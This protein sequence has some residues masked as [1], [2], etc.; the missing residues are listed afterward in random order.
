MRS[1]AKLALE[2]ESQEVGSVQ[3]ED[4]DHGQAADQPV[5]IQ[6]REQVAGEHHVL[7]DRHT[8]GQVGKGRAEEQGRQEGAD[9]D[10]PVEGVPPARARILGAVLKGDA[11]HDQAHQQQEERQVEAAEHRG[12]PVRKSRECRAACSQKPDLVAI[13]GWPNGV[14][15]GAAFL[16]LLS[17]EGEQHADAKI[18]ALQEVEADP[19]DGDQDEPD[20]LKCFVRHADLP[21]SPASR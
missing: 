16:V 12:V 6:Q 1:L 17:Q 18:K 5:R 14:D 9:G 10:H 2:L 11:A 21:P 7:V 4:R 19:Q 20:D 15:D 13:P 8:L 3:Q